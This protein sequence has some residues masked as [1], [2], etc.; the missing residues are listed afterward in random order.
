VTAL[1]TLDQNP[2][3]SSSKDADPDR[4]SLPRN[5]A[6]AKRPWRTR[7]LAALSVSFALTA[8]VGCAPNADQP[9][10][11]DGGR[12]KEKM[13]AVSLISVESLVSANAR[14]TIEDSPYPIVP[15]NFNWMEQERTW[16]AVNTVS[17]HSAR[18]W[19]DLVA[20]LDDE[21]YCVTVK[22]LVSDRDYNW[23]VGDVC[24][25]IIG[26]TLSQA[27]YEDIE[28]ESLS[29]YRVIR[30]PPLARN[31]GSLKKW[32]TERSGKQL[33]ELQ[34]ETC[35]CTIEAL[36]SGKDLPEITEESRQAWI[37]SIERTAT[38]LAKSKTGKPFK[39]FKINEFEAL[40]QPKGDP[41]GDPP[42][43]RD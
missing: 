19:P 9:P 14:P 13:P 4:C 11:S 43:Q 29:L 3:R 42:P 32:L 28:P 30:V 15:T 1:P 18:F 31:S 2:G 5:S 21:R 24:S 33:Y 16:S 17:S 34:I 10:P 39:G 6:P 12:G 22:S 23:S 25:A 27:Y 38:A 41:F 35:E 26:R 8:C 36:H 37:R 40:A 20:H 7:V